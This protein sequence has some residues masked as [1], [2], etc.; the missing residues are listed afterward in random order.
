M[1]KA[2]KTATFS[3]RHNAKRAAEKAIRDGTAPSINYG[4]KPLDN[5]RFEIV[6]KTAPTVHEVDAE[7]AM[8]TIAADD[9]HYSTNASLPV[10]EDPS[11]A[12]LNAGAEEVTMNI[13]VS[14]ETIAVRLQKICTLSPGRCSSAAAARSP[15]QVLGPPLVTVREVEQLSLG[16]RKV[17]SSGDIA[18]PHCE[19]PVMRAAVL[20][21]PIPIVHHLSRASIQTETSAPR[22]IIASSARKVKGRV[23]HHRTRISFF[24]A[25]LRMRRNYNGLP[26][27][28]TE[29]L[30]IVIF[31]L[32]IFNFGYPRSTGGA[33][34]EATLIGS[35][36]G[37]RRVL[38][39]APPSPGHGA[40]D[41]G[42]PAVRRRDTTSPP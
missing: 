23:E 40:T 3:H 14:S 38:H 13:I 42:R 30:P 34:V 33:P 21:P 39:P 10:N 41:H 4:I 25:Q 22:V 37:T 27:K 29:Y 32:V 9:A 15:F 19:F 28:N 12:A 18:E 1:A 8:T 17:A 11:Y 5:G 16:I 36:E 6:W 26:A 35:F 2:S 7:I 20:L 31:L 24:P